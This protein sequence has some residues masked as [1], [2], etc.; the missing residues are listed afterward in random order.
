MRGV[1]ASGDSDAWAVG[2][3][4]TIVH[5]DGGD[6]TVSA[7]GVTD[8][9]YAVWGASK[10]M[11]WAAGANGRVLFYDGRTWLKETTPSTATLRS[12]SGRPGDDKPYV[13]G[14]NDTF[15]RRQ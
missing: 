2:A 5:F 6:W 7:S 4:G 14:D 10:D 9:L 12:I 11:V 8:D 13:I 1:W 3:G 15:M